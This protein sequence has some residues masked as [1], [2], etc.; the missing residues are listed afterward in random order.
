M[1]AKKKKQSKVRKVLSF[2]NPKS[3]KG[4]MALFA[5]VFA[6]G[7]AGFAVYR[8]F[9]ATCDALYFSASGYVYSICEGSSKIKLS[10]NEGFDHVPEKSKAANQLVFSSM[11]YK[12]DGWHRTITTSDLSG[13]NRRSITDNNKDDIDHQ[14]KWSPDG[15]KIAYVRSKS[16]TSSELRIVNRDGTNDRL[17]FTSSA[18]QLGWFLNNATMFSWS[19][20]G[21]KIFFV[22]SNKVSSYSLLSQSVQTVADLGS[23]VWASYL[24]ISSNGTLVVSGNGKIYTLTSN[25]TNLRDL[26][27]TDVTGEIDVADT[28]NGTLIAFTTRTYVSSTESSSSLKTMRLD[29]TNVKNLYT[30]KATDPFFLYLTWD[31]TGNNIAFVQTKSAGSKKIATLMRLKLSPRG[32]ITLDQIVVP[33]GQSTYSGLS[34]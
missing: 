3:L 19:K 16:R 18:D 9:A 1:P 4:G 5:L 23:H 2:F 15:S 26:G 10:S 34:W 14:P 12:S 28:I 30:F 31:P 25:G 17:A 8:S 27:Q 20:D 7:G 13:Q 24:D 33:T 21:S 32:K 22:I 11:G 29:G 6:V